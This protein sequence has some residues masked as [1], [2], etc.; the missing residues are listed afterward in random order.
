ME[1][2]PYVDKTYIARQKRRF[3]YYKPTR[4]APSGKYPLMIVVHGQN[5]SPEFERHANTMGRM[6]E[7]AER[8]GFVVVYANGQQSQGETRSDA[9]Y[10]NLGTWQSLTRPMRPTSSESSGT[11]GARH[12]DRS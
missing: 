8:D 12:P 10:T 2:N 1:P 9:F 3:L 4:E 5:V 7:L 11:H 6:D